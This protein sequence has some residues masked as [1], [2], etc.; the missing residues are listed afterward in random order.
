MMFMDSSDFIYD[1][2]YNHWKDLNETKDFQFKT[3]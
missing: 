1:P 2:D 3:D